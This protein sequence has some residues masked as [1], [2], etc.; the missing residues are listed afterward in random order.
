MASMMAIP[1][2]VTAIKKVMRPLAIGISWRLLRNPP[3]SHNPHPIKTNIAI[4]ITP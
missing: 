4:A 1:I 3:F 2:V